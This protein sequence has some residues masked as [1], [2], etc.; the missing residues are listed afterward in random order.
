MER[1]H[2]SGAEA[3][4]RKNMCTCDPSWRRINRD[5]RRRSLDGEEQGLQSL[6]RTNYWAIMQIQYCSEATVIMMCPG[7]RK[8]INSNGWIAMKKSRA[9]PLSSIGVRGNREWVTQWFIMKCSL[10]QFWIPN[11]MVKSI[12]KCQKSWLKNKGQ[13]AVRR[14]YGAISLFREVKWLLWGHTAVKIRTRA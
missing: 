9:L 1:R 6:H 4:S 11:A 2:E 5:L 7:D 10:Y 13:V 8:L 3:P 14:K 12:E